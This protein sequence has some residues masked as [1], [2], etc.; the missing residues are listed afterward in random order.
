MIYPARFTSVLHIV[1]PDGDSD[2][3]CHE[4]RSMVALRDDG[5]W[6]LRYTDDDNG[7][8]TALQGAPRWMSITR[9]GEVRSHLLFRTDQCLEAV[10]RTPHGDFDLSTHA[11]AYSASVTPDGGRINLSYDLLIDGTLTSKNQLTI[12][13]ESLSAHS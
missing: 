7:G 8:Q 13:W 9:D 4:G 10:Y 1:S 3:I 2:E 6:S 12:E 11:T 5:T